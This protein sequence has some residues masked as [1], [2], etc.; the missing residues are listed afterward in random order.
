MSS[1]EKIKQQIDSLNEQELEK[2]SE[3]IASLKAKKRTD[4]LPTF[5]LSGK[6]DK[7]DI[8]KEAYA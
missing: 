1:R 6:F 8:R 4:G 2:V 5:D 7:M 3:L